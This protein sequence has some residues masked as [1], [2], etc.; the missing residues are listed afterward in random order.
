MPMIDCRAENEVRPPARSRIPTDSGVRRCFLLGF[1]AALALTCGNCTQRTAQQPLHP[2]QT[3]V[4]VVAPM[5][6][7]SNSK[8]FDPL[9]ATDLLASELAGMPGFAVVPVNLTLAELAR[10]GQT[11]V[12]SP[13]DALRLAETFGA[14]ATLVA[15]ITEYQPYDPPV[16]GLVLQWYSARGP[17]EYGRGPSRTDGDAARLASFES[18]E[19]P[20]SADSARAR[21][22]VGPTWQV[23]RVFHAADRDVIRELKEFADRRDRDQSPYK[24]RRFV[25]SQREYLRFCSWSVLRTI[26]RQ[27]RPEWVEPAVEDELS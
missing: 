15:A 20:A 6:N 5:L 9:Q 27:A 11:V 23:Q 1:G 14:D 21:A 22:G 19:A 13:E 10:H 24:W 16:I 18:S 12:E 2:V 26:I 25:K 4:I 8:D 3:A 17:S 7:L